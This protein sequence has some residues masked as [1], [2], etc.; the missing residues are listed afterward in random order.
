MSLVTG[1]HRALGAEPLRLTR[2]S[3]GCHEGVAL[4]NNRSGNEVGDV[5]GRVGPVGS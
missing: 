4:P 5:G 1:L 2:P 3:V